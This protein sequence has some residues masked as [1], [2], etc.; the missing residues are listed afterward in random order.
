[1]PS[2]IGIPEIWTAKLCFQGNGT[3]N[4]LGA[5]DIPGYKVE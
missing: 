3:G 1:M 2:G 5:A 4:P